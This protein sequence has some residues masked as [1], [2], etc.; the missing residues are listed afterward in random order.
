MSLMC[1]QYTQTSCDTTLFELNFTVGLSLRK[2]FDRTDERARLKL[3]GDAVFNLESFG[4]PRHN[5]SQTYSLP[6]SN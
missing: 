2:K 1:T 5:N 4:I 6:K 3:R